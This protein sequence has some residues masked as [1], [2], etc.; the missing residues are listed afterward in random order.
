MPEKIRLFYRFGS[1]FESSDTLVGSPLKKI[2]SDYGQN[3]TEVDFSHI[4]YPNRKIK[5][6]TLY[7]NGGVHSQF[8]YY[9]DSNSVSIISRS[10]ARNIKGNPEHNEM[11]QWLQIRTDSGIFTRKA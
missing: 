8:F 5:Y 2:P 1:G 10:L 11:N 3:K 6:S 4:Y 7:K 9:S